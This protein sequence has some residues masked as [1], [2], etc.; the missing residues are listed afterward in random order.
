MAGQIEFYQNKNGKVTRGTREIPDGVSF[1]SLLGDL[2]SGREIADEF[3]N[4]TPIAHNKEVCS[5]RFP[6]STEYVDPT[7][8]ILYIDIAACG[9]SEDEVRV[10]VDNDKVV[11]TFNKSKEAKSTRLYA[12]KGLKLVTDEVLKF[13]FDPTFHDPN[14]AQVTLDKGILSITIL[15]RPEMKPVRRQ[16]FGI[17]PTTDESTEDTKDSSEQ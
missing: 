11:V 9:I 2:F 17:K 12:Q 6:V 15:P 8:K 14:T 13:R 3:F 16:I 5:N 1:D 4:R 7:D 10:D